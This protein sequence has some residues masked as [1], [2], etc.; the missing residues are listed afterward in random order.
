MSLV[1]WIAWASPP[2]C[3][4]TRRLARLLLARTARCAHELFARCLFSRSSR[5]LLARCAPRVAHEL[6]ALVTFAALS[7]AVLYVS[8]HSVRF[9]VQG[10]CLFCF[11]LFCF[12]LTAFAVLSVEMVAGRVRVVKKKK[13]ERNSLTSILF[14]LLVCFDIK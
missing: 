3:P 11:V 4:T 2:N 1:D 9:K 10:V 13:K 6:F 14:C 12:G 7:L 8:V 5:A